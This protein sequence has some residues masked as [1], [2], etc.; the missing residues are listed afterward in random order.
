VLRGGRS[1]S[2]SHATSGGAWAALGAAREL[3]PFAS[4]ALRATLLLEVG[5]RVPARENVVPREASEVSLAARRSR[6]VPRDAAEASLAA[7]Y[8]HPAPLAASEISHATRAARAARHGQAV[9]LDATESS[10][11]TRAARTARLL[12]DGVP[13]GLRGRTKRGAAR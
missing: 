5:D 13:H 8:A 3:T 10:D 2:S 9:R 12:I 6:R 1:L 7:R 4:L 11:A